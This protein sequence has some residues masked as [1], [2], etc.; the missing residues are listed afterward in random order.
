MKQI[1]LTNRDQKFKKS[2]F[3]YRH[4]ETGELFTKTYT[5]MQRIQGLPFKEVK[6]YDLIA[7]NNYIG[8]KD[9]N[10]KDI[11]EGDILKDDA[12][13][14]WLFV[15]CWDQELASFAAVSQQVAGQNIGGMTLGNYMI[16]VSRSNEVI[17]NIYQN[18]E[19][20]A[21]ELKQFMQTAAGKSKQ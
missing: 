19:R 13:K 10:G 2:R 5:L 16:P 12:E 11:F 15:V 20:Y 7:V 17:G 9:K 3:V 21:E 14:D 8:H 18:P 1:N 6:V 4:R